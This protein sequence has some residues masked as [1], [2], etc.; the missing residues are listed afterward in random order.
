MP[1]QVTRPP[2]PSPE[3]VRSI[4]AGVMD[5]ELHASIVELDMVRDVVV[6]P[7]GNVSVTV[8]L[9]TAGCPLRGQ[10]GNDVRSKVAGLPGVNE[11]DVEYG[12]MTQEQR[13]LVM[14]KARLRA[15]QSAPPTEVAAT[16]RVIAIG[17]GKG[18]VGKSSITANLAVALAE[19]GLAVGLVDADVHGFSI[20]GL[21]GI[22]AGTQPT[23]IDDLM[24][25]PVAH[26]VKTISIGMSSGCEST[27]IATV[28]DDIVTLDMAELED[29]KWVT[30]AEVAAAL[31]GDPGASFGAPPRYAIANTLFQAWLGGT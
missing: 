18:G 16:T 14:Q 29:A 21:L 19:H 26:G 10:I 25:P 8:A 2:L 7:E 20:P 17:S 28:A 12:E 23:R 15:S 31:A 6:S 3:D 13:S 1:D 9:T 24:L 11:V 4:L 5:P 30:R 27:C 22:A